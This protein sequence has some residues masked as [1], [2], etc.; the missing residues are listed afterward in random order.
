M[1]LNETNT[2]AVATEDAPVA[3]NALTV[4]IANEFVV[5][6]GEGASEV[7]AQ[8]EGRLYVTNGSAERIDIF[9]PA[10][11]MLIASIPLDGLDGFD[12]VQS[13]AVKNGIVAAA[14]SRDEVDATVFG[15]DVD[16][17]QPGFIAF[18]DAETQT[19]LSTIDVGNLP[20]Q[21]VFSADGTTLI[22]AGEGEKNGDSD[23]DNNP[24][25]TIA[26]I[27]TTDPAAPTAKIV[28]FAAFNGLEREAREAGIRIQDGVSF[29][30][31]VEPEFVTISPDGMTAFVSLQENNAIAKI[32]IATGEI[33]GIFSLGTVDFSS[34]SQLD[35]NDN[36]IIE[37]RNFDNLV[38]FRMADSITAFD[39]GGQTFIAT[40]NEGDS[41]GFDEALVADLAAGGL[42]DESVDIT[43]L[44]R[45]AI[46]TIDGDTDE[47]G[48]IDVL[49]TFSSRTFSIF[50]A[51]GNLVFDS[52]SDFEKIIAEIAPE[53]FNDD[54]G[55]TDGDE[56]RSN[57]KGPEPEAIT[58][59]EVDGRIYAFIGLERDSGIMIYDVSEPANSSFV[60]YIPPIFVDTAAEGDV[61][62][63]APEIITFIPAA[64]SASGKPQIAVAYE[65][66]GTTIVYD[67][68]AKQRPVINEV[69]FSHAGADN[70]EYVELFGEPG[71]SLGGLSLISFN[72]NADEAGDLNLQIDFTE[73]DMFGDNGF[74]LIGNPT[75]LIA[76]YG[77]SPNIILDD[78]AFENDSQIFALVRT[79][80]LQVVDG[81][82]IDAPETEVLDGVGFINGDLDFVNFFGLP[83]AGPDG[84]FLPAGG[85]RIA[86]GVDTD[87]P[88]D[89]AFADFGLGADNTPTAGTGLEPPIEDIAIFDIQGAGHVSAFAGQTVRTTG[90]VTA[91]DT[92]GYYLQD[93]AG[94][95]DNATSDAIFVFADTGDVAVGDEV[96]ISGLVSE[97]IPGG[98]ASGN[99]STTQIAP[100]ETEILSSGNALPEAT[101][102]G[103]AGRTPPTDVIISDSEL[104]VNL[105]TDPGIFNPD[106]DGIDFYESLEGMRVTVDD[107]TAISATNGFGE[108]F[109][110]AD[111]GANVT[112]GS[113]GGGL[114][115]RGGLNINADIDGT[116]DLNPER[117]QIQYDSGL[118]PEGF[119][120]PDITLGDDLSDI[121]GVV[122]YSFGNFEVLVT[123]A[124]TIETPSA[125]TP[126]VTTIAGTENDLTV[127]TYNVLN[128]T[129]N[130][131][132]GD[133]DQI[134]Q[135]AEQIVA[136]LGSPD[137]L[138]LQEIQDNSGVADDGTLSADET[139]QAIVDAIEAAGGPSYSFESAI[140]DEDGE[141]GGVPGGNIRNAFLY[142]ADRVEVEEIT[143]LEVE[144]LA[145]L[146]VTDPNTFDGTRDP[147]L[148]RFTFNGEDITL[149]N[150]H[151]S[152]RFG[153]DPIF[154]AI[155]PFNQGGEA[156]REA[157]ALA[158]NEVVDSL[159]SSDEEARVVV[160]GDLNT[161]DFTDELTEDLPGIGEERVLTN[162]IGQV[163]TDDVYTFVFRGNS[164]VLD[165]VFATDS[166]L[167]GAEIDIVHVNNDFPDFASDHEPVVVSFDFG[168]GDPI[169][170]VLVGGNGPDVLDGGDGDD[171]I[172]GGN[173]KDILSGGAGDDTILGG[174]G[175]DQIDGDEGDDLL[176]GGNGRDDISGGDGNDHLKGG[177]GRD[178]LSGDDGDDRL[179]GGNGQDELDGGDGND[180]LRGGGGR[181][182]LKGGDGDDTLTGN[183]G[184]DTLDGGAGND[185]LRGGD[186]GDV[187]IF[188]GDFGD[189]TIRGFDVFS[190]DIDVLGAGLGDAEFAFSG[191]EVTVTFDE[192]DATGSI[193]I[194]GF[195]IDGDFIDNLF[196]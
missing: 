85:S 196:S 152:S 193:T 128:V 69:L 71:E 137:I 34:E 115:A 4:T 98:A 108:T 126:E 64:D 146:G 187:F 167:D 91:I 151:W 101:L 16:L 112:S 33:A 166:L 118:L 141:T 14:I 139:L 185:L 94:D 83:T 32:E 105:Q 131:D 158:L 78:N 39:V 179:K 136:N 188:T 24:L 184:R 77:V 6:G 175:A 189:D 21:L 180:L 70:S 9:D 183:G 102:I 165:H 160:L 53:R 177:N 156:A 11:D 62:R 114:N 89:F 96:L 182:D 127:A 125:N 28:D 27:N 68:A 80:S 103:A 65:V 35:A 119:A 142:N 66:S 192:P 143:T 10:A 72:A 84:T 2:T 3:S 148:G 104:P 43:G 171:A 150:N 157:Q 25:G 49:H 48:D 15:Q 59:G 52:G 45:L 106:V 75:G 149:I 194:R 116:G 26:I 145:A 13:V 120:G 81:T 67:V 181:D 178:D 153:S 174:N 191:N 173:G 161:F 92:N 87:S 88:N 132:D 111:D 138:A 18:F 58:I 23:N 86:D 90:I 154:G 123:E 122:G 42:I 164:Q 121:T 57:A 109:L 79:E 195:G 82:V 44:E 8:E 117:V 19:L 50:D 169:D 113:P 60:N 17:A 133:A 162:L 40:A 186:G 37:I 41:R 7:V 168:P 176:F 144:E 134:A 130:L 76:N 135:L 5:E 170:L 56:D 36:G 30:E 38:G 124:F 140:V 55:D 74:L 129:S 63:H 46:S 29:A 110:A 31:D 163:E 93:A 147:L 190:D 12:A 54:D 22:V 61:A 97:F 1:P 47:D 99:L 155:Q 73:D 51:D 172:S 20:D 95:G 107:P 100:S 159:L